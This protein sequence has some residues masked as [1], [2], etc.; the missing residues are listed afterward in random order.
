MM[1]EGGGAW[2]REVRCEM[3]GEGGAWE[4]ARL[5]M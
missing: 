4:K 1:G 5:L 3:L 2:E